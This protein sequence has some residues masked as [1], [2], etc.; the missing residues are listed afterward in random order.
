MSSPSRF[1]RGTPYM[2]FDEMWKQIDAKNGWNGYA[3]VNKI[4]KMWLE[5]DKTNEEL[6]EFF[7]LDVEVI[8]K[9]KIL[10][11]MNRHEHIFYER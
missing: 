3:T 1:P 10:I 11:I 9:V 6:S 2:T 8:R 4:E 5:E 7:E